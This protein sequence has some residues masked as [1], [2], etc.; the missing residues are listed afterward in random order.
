MDAPRLGGAS[1]K[2][3]F[4]I[5][6]LL[7]GT[8]V[9][10][11]GQEPVKEHPIA[12]FDAL[13][14]RHNKFLSSF[15]SRKYAAEAAGRAERLKWPQPRLGYTLDVMT[16]WMGSHSIGHSVQIS[17]ELPLPGARERMAVPWEAERARID[18]EFVREKGD[19]L[20]DLRLDLIELARLDGRLALIADEAGLMSDALAVIEALL[21]VGRATR[22]DLLQLEIALERA[23]DRAEVLRAQRQALEAR[24]WAKVGRSEEAPAG[25]LALEGLLTSWTAEVPEEEVL[26]EWV[27]A[28]SPDLQQTL[29]EEEA[30]Y[31]Q[32]QLVDEQVRPW[33]EVMV[34]YANTAPMWSELEPRSQI[35]QVGISVP[36]PLM[37][38]QYGAEASR[39]QEEAAALADVRAQQIKEVEAQVQGLLVELESDV[40]RLGRYEQELTPLAGDLARDFLI[41]VELGERTSTEYLLALGQEVEL[42]AEIVDLRAAVLAGYVELQRLTGGR[43]GADTAWAYPEWIGGER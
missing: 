41:G 9:S 17:Q 20:R 23:Q 1:V 39:W 36:I 6:I 43:F 18:A 34:G 28:F 2:I 11:F 32:V 12:R 14:L 27:H 4:I 35:F 40:A 13:A 15:T 42:E 8:P 16:P 22:S 25:L 33:P 38:R 21:P 24:L 10:A 26:I 3:A 19:L 29:A 31:A 30:A 37:R 7:L 5:V